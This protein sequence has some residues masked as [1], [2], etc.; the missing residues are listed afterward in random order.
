MTPRK[1]SA[2]AAVATTNTI[3]QVSKSFPGIVDAGAAA[4]SWGGG[5][6]GD[7][8]VQRRA[9]NFYNQTV[10]TYVVRNNIRALRLVIEGF[11]SSE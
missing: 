4:R 5:V 2:K 9:R 10:A 1:F 11:G 7:S 8:G 6:T 3:V